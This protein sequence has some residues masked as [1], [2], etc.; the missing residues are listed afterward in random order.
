MIDI[1]HDSDFDIDLSSGDLSINDSLSQ[2]QADILIATP[3]DYHNAPTM[4]VDSVSYLHS[5]NKSGYLRAIRKQLTADGQTVN[6][7][8]LNANTGELEIDAQY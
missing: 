5:N 8:S 2:A 3:G 4:G 7:L 1:L 6:S